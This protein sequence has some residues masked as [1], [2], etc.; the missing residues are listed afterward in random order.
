[1]KSIKIWFEGL[2]YIVVLAAG[3]VAVLSVIGGIIFV[4]A[5][6]AEGIGRLVDF[7]GQ[8]VALVIL[9]LVYAGMG[10]WHLG[11]SVEKAGGVK[12]ALNEFFN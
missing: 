10:V 12:P 2:A 3:L 4:F 11:K 1:M 8:F 9:L 6:T 5:W 7:P